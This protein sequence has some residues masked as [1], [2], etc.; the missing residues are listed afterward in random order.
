MTPTPASSKF[1][2]PPNLS[3][4]LPTAPSTSVSLP[5]IHAPSNHPQRKKHPL[6]L[7]LLLRLLLPSVPA[8]M[9]H[10]VQDLHIK[11]EAKAPRV[12]LATNLYLL[13][14]SLA[15]HYSLRCHRPH[16]GFLYYP[17]ELILSMYLL[18]LLLLLTPASPLSSLEIFLL[19][20]SQ[21]TLSLTSVLLN[22]T[23]ANLTR[24]CWPCLTSASPPL[25]PLGS[26]A[27]YI[28]P[29][30][31]ERAAFSD[32]AETRPKNEPTA[33]ANKTSRLLED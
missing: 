26:T 9:Y 33:Q 20:S 6:F 11:K 8:A 1:H 7:N 13:H 19:H 4:S 32:V 24:D 17:S 14:S 27:E 15:Q 21:S 12:P 25:R 28:S 5:P 30:T 2:H 10:L 16:E 31:R 29:L 23:N 3:L 22:N 18:L